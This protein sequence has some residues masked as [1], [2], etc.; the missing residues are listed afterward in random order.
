MPL[1]GRE[2]TVVKM[3]TWTPT[4]ACL[5]KKFSRGD[6]AIQQQSSPFSENVAFQL[7]L[8][9][10]NNSS[11]RNQNDATEIP[12]VVDISIETNNDSRVI[13]GT[14]LIRRDSSSWCPPWGGEKNK[15]HSC[16][17]KTQ[18][19]LGTDKKFGRTQ[20][21]RQRRGRRYGVS[22]IQ[23]MNSVSSTTVGSRL[24]QKLKETVG[25]CFPMKT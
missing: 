12:Q 2:E 7:G 21:E 24:R 6:S 8:N 22:S 16:S 17:R 23:D 4:G 14:R 3:W 1:A 13:T 25:L 11:R 18:S 10:S 5:S 20:S 19:S 15:T 9:P